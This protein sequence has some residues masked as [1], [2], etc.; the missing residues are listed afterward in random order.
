MFN[1]RV[2]GILINEHHEVLVSDELIK[3]NYYTKFCGGG[4]E[5]GEGTINC[6]VR[7]FKE[8]MNL[9]IEVISHL[10]TTDFFQKSLFNPN[11]QLIS[12]YYLVK[13]MEPI[14]V[15]IR[16]TAFEFDESQ[17]NIYKKTS[18]IESFRFI[19]WNEFSA[20]IMTLPIDKIAAKMVKAG[21]AG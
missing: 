20:E 1:I 2:Y 7:E 17:L 9:E 8:E 16:T 6:L 15:T 3:G 4:L 5:I 14:N 10:Y 21:K 11:H 12:I 19:K 18:Q 13:A